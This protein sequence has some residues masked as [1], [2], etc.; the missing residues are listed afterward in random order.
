MTAEQKRQESEQDA[1]E[2]ELKYYRNLE[3]LQYP[4]RV[5]TPPGTGADFAKKNLERAK[6]SFQ[7]L[8]ERT[9]NEG[10]NPP[11]KLRPKEEGLHELA[12]LHEALSNY[13]LASTTDTRLTDG[14]IFG[15][16]PVDDKK[17]KIDILSTFLG[18]VPEVKKVAGMRCKL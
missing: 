15:R 2:K 12:V 3:L 18:D 1:I 10:R 4:S 14:Y 13:R 6:S 16:K 8:E 5:V 9:K 17:R 7:R 11:D